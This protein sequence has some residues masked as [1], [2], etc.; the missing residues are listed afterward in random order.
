MNVGLL[1]DAD[2]VDTELGGYDCLALCLTE[3][4]RV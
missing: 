2:A 4:R 3:M 1:G